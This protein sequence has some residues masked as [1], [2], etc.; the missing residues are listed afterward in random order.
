MTLHV[1]EGLDLAN[2][3]V[4]TVA[5]SDKLVKSTEQFVGILEDFALVEALACAGNYLGKQVQGVDVLENV[6]LSIGDENHVKLV[7]GL[8]NE[9]DV[10][11]LDSR[12]LRTAIG[13]FGK[14]GEEGF[15]ARS[16]HLSELSR[17]DSFPSTGANRSRKDD[18]G[19]MST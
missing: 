5:E 14:R 16:W 9:S 11:L 2:G 1:K 7:E 8:V 13:K 18:L 4:L 12:V 3:Q 19:S 15:Y 10:I 6:G 17:E